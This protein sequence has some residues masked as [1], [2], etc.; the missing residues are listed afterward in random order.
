[1]E[2]RQKYCPDAAA[3][4]AYWLLVLLIARL[5][6][7]SA[8]QNGEPFGRLRNTSNAFVWTRKQV[9]L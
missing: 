3:D 4:G 8:C 9:S 6:L 2:Q 1:M 7:A 5:Q